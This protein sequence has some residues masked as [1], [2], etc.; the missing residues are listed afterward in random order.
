MTEFKNGQES[1][2]KTKVTGYTR[3][4]EGTKLDKTTITYVRTDGQ[5]DGKEMTASKF[6]SNFSEEE[7][8]LLK[9]INGGGEAV[10]VKVFEKKDGAPNGFWNLKA[11]KP[12]SEY[13]APVKK[14]YALNNKWGNKTNATSS[15][16]SYDQT[17]A[18]VGGVLH[19]AVAMAVANNGTNVKTYHVASIA[20]EL[21]SLS[22]QLENEVRNGK[23]DNSIS[24]NTNNSLP[25]TEPSVDN[26]LESFD[27]LDDLDN[28]E[29]E[30]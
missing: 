21:L 9:S 5:G 17:G 13:V 12:I 14:E 20:R 8:T 30:L 28:L 16:S 4:G 25:V 15:K 29:I 23:Y 22:L 10:I 3:T 2:Q 19:D 27:S 18:K 24:I 11:L 26:E 7:K 6:T 1:A